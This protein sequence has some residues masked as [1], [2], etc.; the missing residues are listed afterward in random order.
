MRNHTKNT[1]QMRKKETFQTCL[2]AHEAMTIR[3]LSRRTG[4]ST[5]SILRLMAKQLCDRYDADR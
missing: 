3:E 2:D 5:S 4:C 1:T